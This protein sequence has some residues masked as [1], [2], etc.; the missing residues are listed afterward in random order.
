MHSARHSNSVLTYQNIVLRILHS[1]C[2]EDVE[3]F[4]IF[5]VQSLVNTCT[6][7][8]AMHLLLILQYNL[9]FDFRLL[10]TQIYYLHRYRYKCK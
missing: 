9:K 2:S 4:D 10:G 5:H 8:T 7:S 1:K 6:K 3:C